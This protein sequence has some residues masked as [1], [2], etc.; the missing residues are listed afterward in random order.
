MGDGRASKDTQGGRD[1]RLFFAMTLCLALLGCGVR[2]TGEAFMTQQE[3]EAKDD[4][5]CKSLGASPRT[6]VYVDCRLRLRTDRSTQD[7][8]RRFGN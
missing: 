4:G 3:M 2:G 8:L 1:V 6:T 5:I 7:T